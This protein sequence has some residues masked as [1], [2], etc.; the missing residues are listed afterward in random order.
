[1]T[2]VANCTC[3][4]PRYAIVPLNPPSRCGSGTLG[5][6]DATFQIYSAT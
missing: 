2:F 5:V 6:Q 4:V 1:M 3:L